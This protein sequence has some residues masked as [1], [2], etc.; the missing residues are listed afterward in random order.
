MLQF[1]DS[2][3]T[4]KNSIHSY[5]EEYEKL[6]FSRRHDIKLVVEI[7]IQRGGSLKLWRDYFD[8]AQIV[9]IDTSAD[10]NEV[11]E[12][13]KLEQYDRITC[14]FNTDAYDEK[15]SY[16][17]KDADIIIDDGPHTLISQIKFLKLYSKSIKIGG[18]LVV[19]DIQD[20]SHIEVLKEHVEPT[21]E[22]LV[23][24]NRLKKDRYDDVLFVVVRRS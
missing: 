18:L 21:C 23:I 14:M 16:Q 13:L 7:G 20:I 11:G 5:T 22:V 4:D 1:V 12:G 9:G 8:Q 2:N 3:F 15:V 10:T 19:E 6:F 17:I 24:D